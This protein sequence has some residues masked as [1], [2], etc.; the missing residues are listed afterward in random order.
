MK[1]FLSRLRKKLRTA[2]KRNNI[3]EIQDFLSYV[4]EGIGAVVIGFVSWIGRVVWADRKDFKQRLSELEDSRKKFE[5]VVNQLQEDMA[6][7]DYAR[8]AFIRA[9]ETISQH[10]RVLDEVKSDVKGLTGITSETRER[11]GRLEGLVDRNYKA[12]S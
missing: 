7:M 6:K 4:P 5:I 11:L 9:A 8:E 12:A 2:R 3:V 10:G 1:H